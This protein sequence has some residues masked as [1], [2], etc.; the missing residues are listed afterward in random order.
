MGERYKIVTSIN[1]DKLGD[2]IQTLRKKA[3][4]AKNDERKLRQIASVAGAGDLSQPTEPQP[5]Q[6]DALPIH[7]LARACRRLADDFEHSKNTRS[8]DEIRD[9]QQ[10]I[11]RLQRQ[12]LPIVTTANLNSVLAGGDHS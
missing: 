12:L 5:L 1:S 10:A 8:D 3:H 11:G 7:V 2:V 9:L 4:G 6:S